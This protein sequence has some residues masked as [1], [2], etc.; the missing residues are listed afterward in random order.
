MKKT[1]FWCVI[2]F[3]FLT[4]CIF[5]AFGDGDLPPPSDIGFVDVSR[6]SAVN[7][8]H[9]TTFYDFYAFSSD[10]IGGITVYNF[11]TPSEPRIVSH[12][13]LP[14]NQVIRKIEVDWNYNLFLAAGSAGF[15]IVSA[16]NLHNLTVTA[17]DD[18]V[19]ARDISVWEDYIAVAD[20]DG[21]RLYRYLGGFNLIE[22]CRYYDYHRPVEPQKI[23]MD[24]NWIYV[25]N[26]RSLDIFDVTNTT[27]V[28]RVASFDFP[29]NFVDFEI[30][31]TG[32]EKVL[33]VVTQKHMIFFDILRPLNTTL[34]RDPYGFNKTP[35]A[36]RYNQG[37][38][39]IT[40]EDR[41]V[42]VFVI[43]SLMSI[44]ERDE[45]SRKQFPQVVSDVDFYRGYVF[46]THGTQGI[47]VYSIVP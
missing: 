38:L 44:T 25:F 32:F 22:E 20:I 3:I 12:N 7:F 29:S 19:N 23:Y 26:R 33:A 27:K 14:I 45:K 16:A 5:T 4:S 28:D 13:P 46:F 37:N 40:W 24:G 2:L 9:N 41:D 31:R 6:I 30:I 11:I 18:R 8:L 34:I 15:Y 35:R 36:I 47:G 43:Y 17:H 42:S 10:G 21:W 1:L 39:Y